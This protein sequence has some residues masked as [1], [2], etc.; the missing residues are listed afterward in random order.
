MEA[1][2]NIITKNK[3]YFN[4]PIDD[5]TEG[6]IITAFKPDQ[7]TPGDDLR[8]MLRKERKNDT[9]TEGPFSIDEF[10]DQYIAG[11]RLIR[12]S[13]EQDEPYILITL[14]IGKT[15]AQGKFREIEKLDPDKIGDFKISIEFKY[16][17]VLARS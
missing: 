4:L 10:K 8:V 11:K 16:H 5:S 9:E 7:F 13:N 17:K 12:F 2:R 14:F 1:H 6:A 3:P 15:D